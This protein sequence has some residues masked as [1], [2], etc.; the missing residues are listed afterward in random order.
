MGKSKLLDLWPRLSWWETDATWAEIAGS[1]AHDLNN[2]LTLVNLSLEQLRMKVGNRDSLRIHVDRITNGVERIRALVESLEAASQEREPEFE[3]VDVNRAVEEALLILSAHLD[4]ARIE[5]SKQ[6]QPSLPLI[7]GDGEL[8]RVAFLNL[9]ASRCQRTGTG[10]EL[11]IS[12]S[13]EDG[14]EIL[15]SDSGCPTSG[16]AP[17]TGGQSSSC[18]NTGRSEFALKVAKSIVEKHKGKIEVRSGPGERCAFKVRL[19]IK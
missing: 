14:V 16:A 18:G 9:I 7:S 17:E 2:A 12:T 15:F 6:L 19:P 11:S 1:V 8:L 3:P 10:G 5:V 4:R 13:G